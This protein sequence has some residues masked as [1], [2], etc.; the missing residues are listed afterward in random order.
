M[1]LALPIPDLSKIFV[2]R[3][4]TATAGAENTGEKSKRQTRGPQKTGCRA[5]VS[6]DFWSKCAKARAA[7]NLNSEIYDQRSIENPCHRSCQPPPRNHRTKRAAENS[8]SRSHS[9]I[10]AARKGL[11][12]H[13]QRRLAMDS[14]WNRR[15][16]ARVNFPAPAIMSLLDSEAKR[17]ITSSALLAKASIGSSNRLFPASR[18]RFSRRSLRS[19]SEARRPAADRALPN[20]MRTT[21]QLRDP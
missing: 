14:H 4:R 19:S 3:W 6:R 15:C 16:I 8:Q 17:L 10:A 12:H 20:Q 9:R 2:S 7:R 18:C 5:F 13:R 21:S 1:V 11:Y